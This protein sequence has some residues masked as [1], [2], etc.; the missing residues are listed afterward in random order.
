MHKTIIGGLAVA[1]AVAAPAAAKPK[2]QPKP[3][4]P[5][6][7]QC[8][9][10]KVGFHAKGALVS[11]GLTQSAGADTARRGDDRYSGTLTINVAKANHTAATG[12]QTYTVEN[13]RVRFRPH[14]AAPAAGDR[15]T[16]HG[17]TTKVGKKCTDTFTPTVTVRKVDFKAK[18]SA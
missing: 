15:V 8:V 3:G 14:G 16:V 4:K 6:P 10:K 11:N 2:P 7:Y 9:P 13:A 1:V 5:H 18:K 17:R 12:E